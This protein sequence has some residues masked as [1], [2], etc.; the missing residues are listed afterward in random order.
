MSAASGTVE[1]P[2]AP[3]SSTGRMRLAAPRALARHAFRDARV[4]TISFACLFAVIAYIQPVGYR[5]A[6]PTL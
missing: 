1:A 5:Y 6:Y 3:P 2:S 4:R